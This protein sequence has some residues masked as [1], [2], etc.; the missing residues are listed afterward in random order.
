MTAVAAAM[1]ALH[2]LDLTDLADTCRE[3]AV[4][5]LCTRAATPHGPV[6]AI[7]TWPRFVAQARKRLAGS[8]VKIATVINFPDGG[9][10]I[11]RAIND[12]RE[13]LRDG[14]DEI[15]LVLPWRAFL[16]GD[17]A[18]ARE[19]IA[20]VAD[21]TGPDHLL[22]VI[23][24][25]GAL[26]TPEAIAGASRL[27]IAA[28]ANFIKTST[29]KFAVSATPQAAAIMLEEIRACARPVGFKA[30][31]GVRTLAEA[32]IYLALADRIMG[33][34]WATPTTFRLGASSLLDALLADIDRS[35][36][37]GQGG[38]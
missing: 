23:L 9:D 18:T 12:A 36:A 32:N 25:T 30:A 33:P 3:A 15:D 16:A 11:E 8:P 17:A 28:G 7:C 22:K 24:E 38:T 2:L 37:V 20:A 13:A 29:G 19:M 6:A 27:A 31:G 10:A 5:D 26:G 14:A 1:R 4:D 35:A 21:E 34:H